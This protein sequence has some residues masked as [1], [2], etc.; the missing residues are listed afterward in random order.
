MS[1]KL[2]PAR[3]EDAPALTTI[4]HLAKASWGYPEELMREWREYWQITPDLLLELDG[5]VAEK[6]GIPV[7]FSGAKHDTNGRVD[8]DYL[9]VA[10]QVQKSGIGALLL[11]RSEDRARQQGYTKIALRSEVNAGGFYER[12]GYET[13]GQE[14]SQ[15]APGR[16]MPLMEKHLQPAV[17]PISKIDLRISGQPW[18]FEAANKAAISEYFAEKQRQIPELWN[19]RTLKLTDHR[20]EDGV[21]SGTCTECSYAAFLTW[22]DWGAPDL[23]TFNLFGSAV[24]R[25]SEGALLYG[26]MSP[27]TATAGLI[28]PM[29]GNLDPSDVNDSGSIDMQASIARELEEETGLSTR[30]LKHEELL[31][32]FDG[33]RIS[34]SQ[35]F[36]C[37]RPAEDLRA[38]INAHSKA[39][40]EQ[41]LADVRIIKTLDD[42]DDPAIVPY[43]KDLG[44][45]LLA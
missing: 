31:I 18:T 25:S 19:G 2:R 39:S 20:F 5:I 29:G 10:P 30:Q 34:V 28:Y 43:A 23:T 6:N 42:L 32:I 1:L 13:T 27:H 38:A 24:L 4:M 37:D 35:V 40:A 11:M 14:P 9:Y 3:P 45:H 8:L 26:V 41:E 33:A 17:Y 7:A 36:D 16:F 44:R 21:L 15:M 22:R 12:C